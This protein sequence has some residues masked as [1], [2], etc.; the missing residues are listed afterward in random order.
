M[1]YV[2][3]NEIDRDFGHGHIL[4]GHAERCRVD[5]DS[6]HVSCAHESRCDA[7]DAAATPQVG[8][9]RVLNIALFVRGKKHV[10]GDVR[11]CRILLELHAGLLPCPNLAKLLDQVAQLARHRFVGRSLA[12]YFSA[13]V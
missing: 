9:E 1:A 8:D 7:E 12:F 4:R 3:E 5:V 11:R 10:G 13:N 2:A 6:C